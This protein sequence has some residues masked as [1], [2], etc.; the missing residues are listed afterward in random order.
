LFTVD[1]SVHEGWNYHAWE[2][3]ADYPKYRF[4][5]FSGTKTGSCLINEIKI[6]GVETIDI[7]DTDSSC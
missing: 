5:K 3:P 1:E 7:S 4:Y 2:D 6:T